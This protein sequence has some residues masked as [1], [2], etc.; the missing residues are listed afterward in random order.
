MVLP[1]SVWYCVACI[2]TTEVILRDWRDTAAGTSE[3]LKKMLRWVDRYNRTL[4]IEQK[5][6]RKQ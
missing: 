4:P 3:K 2:D 5:L 6:K 1:R